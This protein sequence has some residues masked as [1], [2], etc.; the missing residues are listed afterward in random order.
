MVATIQAY[1]L[2]FIWTDL[3]LRPADPQATLSRLR[4]RAAFEGCVEKLRE[5]NGNDGAL[6]L[7]WWRSAPKQFFWLHYFGGTLPGNVTGMAAWQA[8]APVGLAKPL[9]QITTT[10]G[11]CGE[12]VAY[13]APQAFAV[14]ANFKIAGTFAGE[15]W[16]DRCQALQR[17][18]ADVA[19]GD[20]AA[21]SMTL[22]D[23]ADRSRALLRTWLGYGQAERVLGE[24]FSV[25]TPYK[26]CGVSGETAPEPAYLQ[27]AHAVSGW[28]DAWRQVAPDPA[29][30]IAQRPR[31]KTICDFM[32]GTKRGR[33]LWMPSRFLP[34]SADKP[35]NTLS[36]YHH[37]MTFAAIQVEMLLEFVR[38]LGTS[39]DTTRLAWSPAARRTAGL[40][41]RLHGGTEDIYR[42]T[43][44]ARHIRDSGLIDRI[45]TLRDLYNM[46]GPRLSA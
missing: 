43:S 19:I 40:L 30:I 35:I 8:L 42:S 34:R 23:A 15:D 29:G 5:T 26:G 20:E 24:A 10:D 6:R 38:A 28:P 3:D 1:R 41:G 27:W 16:V 33:T 22:T 32:Y 44:I 25:A 17:G 37:N 46:P 11:P 9:A 45:N 12:I 21:V 2:S 14:V 4:P 31:D 39:D 13:V 36:C 7:P 18:R